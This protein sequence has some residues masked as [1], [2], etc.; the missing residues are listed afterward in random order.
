MP[1]AS[2][3]FSVLCQTWLPHQ[4]KIKINL[5]KSIFTAKALFKAQDKTEKYVLPKDIFSSIILIE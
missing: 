2:Q 1:H 5:N 4:K 3:L